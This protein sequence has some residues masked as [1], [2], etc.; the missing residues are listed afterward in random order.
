MCVYIY[1]YISWNEWQHSCMARALYT[2]KS[3]IH[4][5]F[6]CSFFFFFFFFQMWDR[7]RKSWIVV[8]L[9]NVLLNTVVA[10]PIYVPQFIP[11]SK[12]SSLEYCQNS[13]NIYIYIS[14]E[15][16]SRWKP[17]ETRVCKTSTSFRRKEKEKKK[18]R[19][20]TS[21]PRKIIILDNFSC[22]N[23]YYYYSFYKILNRND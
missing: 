18:E 17:S 12:S 15:F 5:C 9:G 1:I 16:Q 21:N 13:K 19:K 3:E 10:S 23:A 22:N 7:E 4:F 11:G 6:A 14:R 8:F 20:K 2:S